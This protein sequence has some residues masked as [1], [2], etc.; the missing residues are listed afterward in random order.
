MLWLCG[1][2]KLGVHLFFREREISATHLPIETIGIYETSIW[3]TKTIFDDNGEAKI[4]KFFDNISI[5][6]GCL[7]LDLSLFISI[8]G[9]SNISFSTPYDVQ[10]SQST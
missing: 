1:Q 4:N 2:K 7:L 5:V 3:L 9:S 6:I 10:C 8:K